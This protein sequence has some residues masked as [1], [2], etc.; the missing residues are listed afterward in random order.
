MIWSEAWPR[1]MPNAVRRRSISRIVLLRRN[2]SRANHLIESA[3]RTNHFDKT[4][5]EDR[6]WI[7]SSLFEPIVEVRSQGGNFVLQ[8]R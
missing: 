5:G 7:V 6:F 4:F 8:A 3:N 1:A 2:L